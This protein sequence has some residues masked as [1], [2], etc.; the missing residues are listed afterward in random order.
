MKRSLFLAIALLT[1]SASAL[2][3]P[4]ADMHLDGNYMNRHKTV[5]SYGSINLADYLADS[6]ST[7]GEKY[8]E[9]KSNR[10]DFI[11]GNQSITLGNGLIAGLS[12]VCG[13]KTAYLSS[14]VTATFFYGNDGQPIV[15]G[16]VL[17]TRKQSKLTMGASF[18][19]TDDSYMGLTVSGK[20]G[21]NAVINVETSENLTTQAKGYLIRIR[22]GQAARRG[23]VYA[24]L[25]Y[26][27][28][29][30]GAVSGYSFYADMDDSKGLRIESTYKIGDN[31]ALTFQQDFA[32]SLDNSEKRTTSAALTWEV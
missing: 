30:P 7:A 21:E 22:H 6:K 29:E 8:L 14:K 27:Y 10:A 28:F 19:K 31:L 12:G 16:E 24:A 4:L 13:V 23:D 5:S 11:I 18:F 3:M 15:A 1:I 17:T 32:T 26:R 25:S 2:A 9:A 20:F